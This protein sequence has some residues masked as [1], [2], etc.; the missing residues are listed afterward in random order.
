MSRFV[1]S[2]VSDEIFAEVRATMVRKESDLGMD[3]STLG[4]FG[5]ETIMMRLADTSFM[6]IKMFPH[7][8]FQNIPVFRIEVYK[9]IPG[10]MRGN[11]ITFIEMPQEG[12]TVE[13]IKTFTQGILQRAG[14][15]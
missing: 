13:E 2:Q 10:D 12:S 9:T 1:L 6:S 11:R 4:G 15:V 7:R 14:L 5:Q 3:I 8:N